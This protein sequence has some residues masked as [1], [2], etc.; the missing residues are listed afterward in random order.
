[1]YKKYLLVQNIVIRVSNERSVVCVEKLLTRNLSEKNKHS[2]LGGMRPCT[3]TITS[4]NYA[5]SS[6]GSSNTLPFDVLDF[7]IL[8]AQKHLARKC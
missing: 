2:V 6:S 7:A 4:N 3:M 5:Y 1:M 8:N